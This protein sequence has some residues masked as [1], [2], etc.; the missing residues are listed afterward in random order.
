MSRT[1]RRTPYDPN[2]P[3]DRRATESNRGVASHLTPLEV[4]DPY[5]LG[6]KI[7]VMRSTRDDPLSG[8]HARKTINEAQYHA[9][10]AFQ[11]DFEAAERGPCAIDPSKEYVDGGLAPEPITEA[12]QRAARQ[13]A[14]CYRQLGADGSA[15]VHD[16]LIGR[17]TLLVVAKRRGLRGETWEKYFGRRLHEC[18]HRLSYVYGLATEP[19]GRERVT[20]DN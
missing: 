5:E 15:L 11:R 1:K 20:V 19:T 16:V 13:L 12:Q 2:K 9:G 3:H 10:L 14:V 18:L 17:H 4:D 7:I 6:A 8:M